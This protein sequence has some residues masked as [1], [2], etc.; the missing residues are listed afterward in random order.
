MTISPTPDNAAAFLRERR[1]ALR[2]ERI[3]IFPV[4]YPTVMRFEFLG[5]PVSGGGRAAVFVRSTADDGTAGWGQSVPVPRWSYETLESAVS[6]LE[7]YLIPVVKGM[8]P[9]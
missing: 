1:R 7:R 6:T 5:G 8:N 4:R 2:I 9:F 3:D